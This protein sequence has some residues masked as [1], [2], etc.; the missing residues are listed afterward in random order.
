MTEPCGVLRV[1]EMDSVAVGPQERTYICGDL[2]GGIATELVEMN[3]KLEQMC[4]RCAGEY[5][6]QGTAQRAAR[7]R[8][9][10]A[11]K[12]SDA[13][14]YLRMLAEEFVHRPEIASWFD[15]CSLMVEGLAVDVTE[16]KL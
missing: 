12:L 16:G 2:D 10:D 6:E 11:G 14:G 7:D 9:D 15:Q 13:A 3:G 5:I 1:R 4:S 8:V